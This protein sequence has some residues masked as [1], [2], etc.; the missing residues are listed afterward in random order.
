MTGTA[1][2]NRQSNRVDGVATLV[3]SVHVR[4]VEISRGGCRLECSRRLESGTSGQLA[5]ELAG[6]LRVDDIRVARCQARIGA[7]SVFQV[8]AELL[9]TR[10][11]GRRTIRMAVKNIISGE[12]AVAHA[13]HDDEMVSAGESRPKEVS[14]ESDGRGPPAESDRGP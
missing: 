8:G 6:L 9:K 12:R 3:R 10:R 11:L 7:G 5:M 13:P 14:G 1:H 4:L 2:E